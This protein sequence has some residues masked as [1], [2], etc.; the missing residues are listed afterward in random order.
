MNQEK[1]GKFL[2]SLRKDKNLTQKEVAKYIGVTEQAVSKWE[3]GLGIPDV[4]LWNSIIELFEIS[5]VE[6]LQGERIEKEQEDPKAEDMLQETLKRTNSKISKMKSK[7]VIILIILSLFIYALSLFLK[8]KWFNVLL[9]FGAS[10]I[11]IYFLGMIFRKWSYSKRF[12]IIAFIILTIILGYSYLEKLSILSG[13]REPIFSI[14]EI[15]KEYNVTVYNSFFYDAY[16]CDFTNNEISVLEKSDVEKVCARN[17]PFDSE[18]KIV[19]LKSGATLSEEQLEVLKKFRDELLNL[20]FVD[21]NYMRQ[22]DLNTFWDY[23]DEKHYCNNPTNNLSNF[24][25]KRK[26]GVCQYNDPEYYY[27]TTRSEDGSLIYTK[28]ENRACN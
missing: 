13:Y 19:V 4:S 3:R 1:L 14:K 5:I 26:N 7:E 17:K 27:C 11:V 28:A 24:V 8:L 6:L 25:V 18:D 10:L 23:M 22:D 20:G 12:L 9:F 15:Y 16:S 2:V 21:Y